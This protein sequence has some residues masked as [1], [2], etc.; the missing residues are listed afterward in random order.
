MSENKTF[1]NDCRIIEG[2]NPYEKSI[3]LETYIDE[4]R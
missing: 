3:M 2:Y 1:T 4:V